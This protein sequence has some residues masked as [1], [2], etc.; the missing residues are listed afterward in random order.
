MQ[1]DKRSI[2]NVFHLFRRVAF[3][4]MPSHAQPR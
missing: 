1:A 4:V 3:A 2:L